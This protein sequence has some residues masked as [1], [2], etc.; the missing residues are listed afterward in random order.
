[1]ETE[2]VDAL[3][4]TRIVLAVAVSFS[5]IAALF[6]AFL[7]WHTIKRTA[8]SKRAEIH[9]RFQSEI[10]TIQQ[11][12]SAGVNDPE[13]WKPTQEEKRY[14]RMYWYAVFDEWLVTHKEDK[15]LM[16]LWD[17]YYAKG[18]SSALKNPHFV[19][20]LRIFFD[21]ESALFGYRADFRETINHLYGV[22]NNG[23]I[24]IID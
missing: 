5:S 3:A 8:A 24:L 15:S 14:I 23:K 9:S 11:K 22:Y 13:N 10:R 4:W 6:A 18:V 1:M 7:S 2:L 17:S 12:F 21:G 19:G 16:S 20:D